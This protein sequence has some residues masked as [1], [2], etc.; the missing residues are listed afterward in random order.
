MTTTPL[1]APLLR[2]LGS[3]SIAS[4]Q[5]FVALGA[6][7]IVLYLTVVPEEIAGHWYN[8]FG[9]VGAA[10]IVIRVV[11]LRIRP[12]LSHLLLASSLLLLAMGDIVYTL[13][14]EAGEVPFPSVAD[15]VYVAGGFL[16]VVA[17]WNRYGRRGDISVTIEALILMTGGGII[18]WQLLIQPI[19]VDAT[20]PIET[21]VAIFFPMIDILL[22]GI[23]ARVLLTPARLTGAVRLVLLAATAYLVSDVVY[24][25]QAL[26]DGYESGLLDIGWLAG[27]VLFAASVLHP[28]SARGVPDLPPGSVDTRPRLLVLAPVMTIAPLLLLYTALRGEFES[29][30][31]L[32]A[33][34]LLLTV[35]VVLRLAIALRALRAALD[36]RR[37]L[38]VELEHQAS[39]DSLTGLANRAVL[40][41]RL[42]SLLAH[43][44]SVAVLFIDLDDFKAINDTFGHEEGDRLLTAVADRIASNLRPTDLGARL[45]GD[46]F[47]VVLTDV[48]DARAAEA[49]AQRLLDAL[50]VPIDL[51][52][53]LA[54]PRASI[55]IALDHGQDADAVMRNADIAMYLAKG[56][57][58]DRYQTF[59]ERL[60]ADVVARLHVRADLE[61]AIENH[62]F[63]VHYQ[64]IFDLNS[65]ELKGS[66]ALVRWEH[67]VRGLVPPLE[68]I[69]IAETTGLIVEL[70]RWVM[71]EALT[72]TRRWQDQMNRPDLRIAVNV[73][74]RQFEHPGFA[75]EVREALATAGIRP[76]TLTLEI[77]ESAILDTDST[78][79]MLRELKQIGVRIAV[80]D[81]GTGY[82]SLSYVGRLPIDELKI[83]RAFISSLGSG[84]KEAAL[85]ASVIQLGGKLDLVTVAEGIEE[86][87]QLERLQALGCDLAQGFLLARP[88]TVDAFET[89]VR[90]RPAQAPAATA[91]TPGGVATF[92]APPAP[93][94]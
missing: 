3:R 78:L 51:G 9:L 46:E 76:E 90:T 4:W 12:A 54:L 5:L 40:A 63:V 53:H 37:E 73:S 84:S 26:G 65:G 60:H 47:A 31:A 21:M 48:V 77:T 91:A 56:Q 93:A 87:D 25:T 38:Q 55:G 70:G 49:T 2:L 86:K 75:R 36:Q 88:M 58:K 69:D 15:A 29:V 7:A 71:T 67:P 42:Q 17:I 33:G 92:E 50:R 80:D 85:A 72:T 81:F 43:G 79:V 14:E 74:P 28:S 89:F 24:S 13:L 64:P 57:G 34:G 18:L 44:R 59:D 35:L 94:V 20:D 45:G 39:H 66:E 22:I 41:A 30:V 52:A 32:A 11:R 19:V 83:D 1:G 6:I 61:Q 62:E 82:S 8:A 27:Y 23:L 68:F 10:A 16:L